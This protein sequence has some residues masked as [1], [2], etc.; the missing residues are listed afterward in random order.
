MVN[1]FNDFSFLTGPSD[2]AHRSQKLF[3]CEAIIE[4]VMTLD[5]FIILS[6]KYISIAQPQWNLNMHHVSPASDYLIYQEKS[7]RLENEKFK[8]IAKKQ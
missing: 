8:I 7:K 1:K 4:T 3:T 5:M 6:L 2:R